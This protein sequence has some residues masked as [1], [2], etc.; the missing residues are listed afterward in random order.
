MS[1]G[2]PRW[3]LRLDPTLVQIAEK[4]PIYQVFR[5]RRAARTFGERVRAVLLGGRGGSGLYVVSALCI[6]VLSIALGPATLCLSFFLPFMILPFLR[7]SLARRKQAYASMPTWLDGVFSPAGLNMQVVVDLWLTGVKGATLVEA[8]YADTRERTWW[9]WSA[10]GAWVATLVG[11]ILV[12]RVWPSLQE[13]LLLVPVVVY[14][15]YEFHAVAQCFGI[16][17]AISSAVTLRYAMWRGEFSLSNLVMAGFGNGVLALAVVGLIALFFVFSETFLLQ[18]LGE[19]P[20]TGGIRSGVYIV[21][22]VVFLLGLGFRGLGRVM[23]DGAAYGFQQE[24]KEANKLFKTFITKVVRE[25][26]V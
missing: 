14:A 1:A 25:E 19:R 7:Q 9:R 22:G 8:M 26:D 15:G 24:L 17:K 11:G 12:W 6:V 18:V 3:V 20:A 5:D 21:S 10:A 13:G 2:L 16:W 23:S 4:N